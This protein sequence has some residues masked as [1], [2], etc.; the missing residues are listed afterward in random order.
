[1]NV[2]CVFLSVLN[3]ISPNSETKMSVE[4]H[5]NDHLIHFHEEL[6]ERI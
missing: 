2:V 4:T 5:T 3:H 6:M 1:M